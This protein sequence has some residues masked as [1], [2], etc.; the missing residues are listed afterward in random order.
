MLTVK[1]CG[2]GTGLALVTARPLAG[3]TVPVAA[4]AG[5]LVVMEVGPRWAACVA[6]HTAQ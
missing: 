4:D 5:E 3:V 1:E 6:R 2:G